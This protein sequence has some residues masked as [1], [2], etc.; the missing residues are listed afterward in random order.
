MPAKLLL[1]DDAVKDIQDASLYYN[2]QQPGLGRRFEKEV[3]LDIP[4]HT[5]PHTG[6]LIYQK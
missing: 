3:R 6:A 5:D 1:L 4:E 2:R